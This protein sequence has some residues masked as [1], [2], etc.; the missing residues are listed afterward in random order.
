MLIIV[1]K[2][3]QD[4]HHLNTCIYHSKK[5]LCSLVIN[6]SPLVI[7]HERMPFHD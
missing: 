7:I 3:S 6:R 1:K 2:T 4:V 5:H